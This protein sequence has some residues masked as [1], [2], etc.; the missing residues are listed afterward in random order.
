MDD[1]I[2]AAAVAQGG[3]HLTWLVPTVVFPY[4]YGA[5]AAGVAAAAMA[6]VTYIG[7]AFLIAGGTYLAVSGT[8]QLFCEPGETYLRGIGGTS[9]PGFSGLPKGC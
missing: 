2:S 5:G 8:Y 9:F 7:V 1:L 4:V 3:F 6:S